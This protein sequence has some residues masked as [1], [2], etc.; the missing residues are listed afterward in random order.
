MNDRFQPKADIL[1]E[2]NMPNS[3][4]RSTKSELFWLWIFG[5]VVWSIFVFLFVIIFDPF[6]Y[7]GLGN[8]DKSAFIEMLYAMALPFIGGGIILLFL[9]YVELIQKKKV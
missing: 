3:W 7:G 1:M 9:K 2:K 4:W 5:F 6:N 8:M